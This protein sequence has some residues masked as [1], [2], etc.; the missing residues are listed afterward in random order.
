MKKNLRIATVVLVASLCQ[1][2]TLAKSLSI[3][4]VEPP[5]WW[6][7]MK[8]NRVQLMLYGKNLKG[9]EAKFDTPQI[10]VLAVHTMANPDYAFVDIEI[11]TDLA[12]GMYTLVVRNGKDQSA[13]NIPVLPRNSDPLR[14]AGFGP[15]D[16]V[17]LITPDRFANGNPSNDRTEDHFDEFDPRDPAKRHGGDLQGIIDNLDYLKDLGVTA[18]W[19]NPVLEN[20][21]RLSY[22]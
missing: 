12:P 22:H 10:K 5:N 21:G 8:F 19:L 20:N 7:G 13:I 2:I 11:P 14:H 3:G 18:L 9:I 4:T 6:A 16:V 15:R 1:S 17:Y